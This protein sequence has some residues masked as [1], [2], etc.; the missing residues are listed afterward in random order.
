MKMKINVHTLKSLRDSRCYSQEQ[1]A[2]MAGLS[3]RTVQRIEAKGVASQESVKSIA[4]VLE[5]SCEQ[6]LSAPIEQHS[7]T[8]GS[9]SHEGSSEHNNQS[10][11]T[12]RDKN[13]LLMSLL[14]VIAANCFGFWGIY[15]AYTAERIDTETMELLKNTVSL[16][17]L[18]SVSVLV[19]KGY[20]RGLFK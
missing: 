14:F 11:G 16:A 7:D 13:Q 1:L 5:V 15:D 10:S 2:M 6:L 17:L 9:L 18:F 4:A 20:K 8:I 19:Y 12:K 3:I